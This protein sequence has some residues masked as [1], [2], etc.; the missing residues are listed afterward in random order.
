MT[1][2]AEIFG[3]QIVAAGSFNPAIFSPDWLER[4]G[5]IGT[6]DAEAA[7]KSQSFMVTNQVS[8]M[9]TDWFTLQ[10]LDNQLSFTSK[11]ALS[12]AFKDL[13]VG[14]LSLVPQTPIAAIGINFMGHFRIAT[15]AEYHKIGDVLAPK[16]IW[17]E[18]FPGENISAGVADL[19]ILI[20]PI[21]RGE[22]PKSGNAVR[23]TLQPSSRLKS[24]VYLLYNDHYVTH[25]DA[26]DNLTMAEYA[27]RVVDD[28]WQSSWEESIR[29]FDGLISKALSAE[30]GSTA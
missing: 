22:A 6:L 18:L 21:T 27:A 13:A 5:L 1:Y 10:V 26:A 30:Q 24:G 20:E 25:E 28:N 4:N 8:L 23:I 7:R 12:P 15:Q 3:S 16:K 9:E 14:V 17:N 29:V 19:T 11:D 2:T